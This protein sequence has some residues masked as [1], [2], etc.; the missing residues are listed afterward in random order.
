[1][2]CC[3]LITDGH[4]TF[5][6]HFGK[7]DLWKAPLHVAAKILCLKHVQEIECQDIQRDEVS[8]SAG[9]GFWPKGHLIHHTHTY[10]HRRQI[11]NVP[12]GEKVLKRGRQARKHSLFSEL[13]S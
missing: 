6:T 12:K 5:K 7:V 13:A 8:N 3:L 11:V 1:M 4:G 2:V 9:Y 10:Y